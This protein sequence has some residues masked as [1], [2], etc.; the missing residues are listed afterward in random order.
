MGR[1]HEQKFH[2][3]SF[4]HGQQ[5]HEKMLHITC[6]QGNTNQ[7]HN[8]TPPHTSENGENKQSR[9]PQ[10]WERMGIKGDPPALLVGMWTGAATLENCVEVPQRV[11]N[12]SA[13]WPSNCIAGNLPQ[14]Y[15]CSETPGHVHPYIS[16]SNVP[17]SQTV[18]GASVSIEGWMD[19][20]D[21]VYVYNGILLSH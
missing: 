10:M 21:V 13:L 12:R 2:Q 14:R 3:R 19:K 1:R 18:E 11:K 6:H 15:R 4:T 16:S 9:K 5:A 8:E 7:N 17:N 20:E